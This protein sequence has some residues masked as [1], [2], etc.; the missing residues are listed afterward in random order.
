MLYQ[1]ARVANKIRI[2]SAVL[3]G[4]AKPAARYLRNRVYFKLFGRFLR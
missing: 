2:A 4:N 1:T 3:H